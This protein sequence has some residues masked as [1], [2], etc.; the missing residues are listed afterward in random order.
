MRS[1]VIIFIAIIKGDHY[2]VIG[3]GLAAFE[4]VYQYVEADDLKIIITQI[5]Q[6][7]AKF[8]GGDRADSGGILGNMVID[9]HHGR[10]GGQTQA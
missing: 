6:M 8:S 9:Q 1:G 2:R 3:N 5:L 10:R 4:L 7:A